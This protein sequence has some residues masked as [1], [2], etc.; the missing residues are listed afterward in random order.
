[1]SDIEPGTPIPENLMPVTK[2]LHENPE[3]PDGFEA[4]GKRVVHR[5]TH[6]LEGGGQGLTEIAKCRFE[7]WAQRIAK[8]LNNQ[9]DSE[10]V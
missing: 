10:G 7:S 5:W 9:P 4:V 6:D 3:A 2:H 1:M 8:A